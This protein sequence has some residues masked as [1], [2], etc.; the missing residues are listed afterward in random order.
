M[1][2]GRERA[3]KGSGGKAGL[4]DWIALKPQKIYPC[5]GKPFP[6]SALQKNS[7]KLNKVK[8]YPLEK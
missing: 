4:P 6:V 1:K 7:A 3:K 2:Q 5:H 8:L